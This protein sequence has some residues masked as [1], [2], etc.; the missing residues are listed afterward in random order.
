MADATPGPAVA[1]PE[2]VEIELGGGRPGGLVSETRL[3]ERASGTHEDATARLGHGR[4][5]RGRLSPDSY[6]YARWTRSPVWE[7]R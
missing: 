7:C 3:V 2:G 1:E 5:R 4:E 6:V